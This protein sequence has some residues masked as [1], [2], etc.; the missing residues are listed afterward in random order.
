MTRAPGGRC[1][2]APCSWPTPRICRSP[3]AKHRSTPALRWPNTT[4]TWAI[5]SPCWP[6]PP[7]AGRKPCA[8]SPDGSKRCRRRRAFPPI[9]PRG[10]RSSTS[11]PATLPRSAAATDP[12]APS[13]RCRPRAATS[14]SRSRCTPS[15]SCAAFGA[16]TRS[17]RTRGFSPP[18]TCTIRTAG[19]P[20]I[21]A[22]GGGRAAWPNGPNCA[23]AHGAGRGMGV[24]QRLPA[25]ER[26]R[27]HRSL[28][29]A[30]EAAA[31]AA[32]R[33]S[34]HRSGH[35]HCR[36]EDPHLPHQ[37]AARP[38]RSD[39][40][41]LR[42]CRHCPRAVRYTGANDHRTDGRAGSGV[43]MAQGHSHAGLEHRGLYRIQGPL[44]FVRGVERVGFGELAEIVSPA[45]R[46]L[47]GRVLELLEDLAVVEVLQGTADL[48]VAETRVRFLGSPLRIPV[49]RE[50]LGRVFDALGQPLDGGPPAL[51]TELRDVNGEAIN[52]VRRDYPRDCIQ[53]GISS[54]DGMNTLVR[55]QKLPIFSAS[56]LPHD[57]LAAQIVRQATLPGKTEQ[58]AVVF[59]AIGVNHD[60]AE[61]FQRG[62]Q[63]SGAFRT[64][65]LF[66]N[67]ADDP[68]MERLVTP[69]TA[70]TLAEF[71]AFDL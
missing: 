50:M 17:W 42:N 30:G 57:Q 34:L 69:R 63:E 25:A 13:E 11:A 43:T 46:L 36:E 65:V 56:G 44:L 37:G 1:S 4:V 67:L 41:A 8:R 31:H 55:G 35:A 49:A 20:R 29:H 58:F 15:A 19:T 2:N 66:L 64:S 32:R 71:L 47:H 38:H 10:W 60:V 9:S 5:T 40:H 22:S 21:W 39:A 7:H 61:F 23:R 27:P 54:I 48:S 68:T 6:T 53:T 3:R 18:S 59:A 12:S 51:G 62:L 33:L 52:P 16:W 45:G 24:A 26:V 70:L 14:R 28:Q